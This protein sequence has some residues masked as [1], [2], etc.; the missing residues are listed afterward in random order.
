VFSL[1]S[2]THAV[3]YQTRIKDKKKKE[4]RETLSYIAKP[5]GLKKHDEHRSN[6]HKDNGVDVCLLL[7]VAS[8]HTQVNGAHGGR[9]PPEAAQHTLQS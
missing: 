5:H 4:G 8:S 2:A 7:W 6:L 1:G 9:D 3:L